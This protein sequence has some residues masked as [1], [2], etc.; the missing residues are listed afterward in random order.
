M[1]KAVAEKKKQIK[2][3]HNVKQA[4]TLNSRKKH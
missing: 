3:I 1:P 4:Y 2:F